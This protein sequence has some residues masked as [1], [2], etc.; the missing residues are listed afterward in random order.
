MAVLAME[1]VPAKASG[2]MYT[3]D[4]THPESNRAI[5]SAVWG[6]G[7]FA[8]DGTV[9]D[10]SDLDRGWSVEIAIPFAAIAEC[11]GRECPPQP[12]DT[13]RVNFS[14]VEWQAKAAGAGYEKLVDPE[15]GQV[16]PENN[17]VWSP[18]GLIAMHYPEMW[19][20]VTFVD[21]PAEPFVPGP[22]EHLEYALRILYYRER[23]HRHET[24]SFTDELDALGLR[25]APLDGVPWPPELHATPGLFEAIGTLGDGTKLR[26]TQDGRIR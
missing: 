19:G 23:I 7:K 24:G 13:W 2:V 15:T 3:L 11:A 6:L 12:G 5:I 25:Q 9:N 17:W 1:I 20:F 4:P 18:Q 21:G 22:R 10:P 8:V 14:R 16:L 26:I